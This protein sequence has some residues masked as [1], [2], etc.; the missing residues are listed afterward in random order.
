MW[1]DAAN[2]DLPLPSEETA[3]E[4]YLGPKVAAPDLVTVEDFF[5]FYIATSTP[6]LVDAPTDKSINAAVEWFFCRV[7]PGYWDRH[8]RRT[9]K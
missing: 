5:H 6:Q 4:R 2:G 3:R 9:Q 8:Q 7:Y 1:R